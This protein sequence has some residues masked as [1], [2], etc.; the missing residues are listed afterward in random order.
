MAEAM[1]VVPSSITIMVP[2]KR[3]IAVMSLQSVV[4]PVCE[5]AR[6][7]RVYPVI[8]VGPRR[9]ITMAPMRNMVIVFAIETAMPVKTPA[10]A[11]V[12]KVGW[13]IAV[14]SWKSVYPAVPMFKMITRPA[15]TE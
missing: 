7:M 12:W 14:I 6:V 1:V 4:S 13:S 10:E 9:A 5:V 8:P 15:D 11:A 3:S 2:A